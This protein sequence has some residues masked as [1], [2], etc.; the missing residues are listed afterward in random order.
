MWNSK[1]KRVLIILGVMACMYVFIWGMN[2]DLR[3]TPFC[4]KLGGVT[5]ASATTLWKEPYTYSVCKPA[6]LSFTGNL[7]ISETSSNSHETTADI[8]IWPQ[9]ISNYEVRLDI[10]VPVQVDEYSSHHVAKSMMLDQNMKLLENTPENVELYEQNLDKIE[11]L[12]HKAYE[13]WG[14]LGSEQ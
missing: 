10:F 5:G 12:Y 3:Y 14:I 9:G 7:G 11:N 6:F 2:A 1:T 8:I 4:K 13:M